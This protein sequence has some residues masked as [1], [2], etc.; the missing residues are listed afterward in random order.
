MD[1]AVSRTLTRTFFVD[2]SPVPEPFPER[3]ILVVSELGF[4]SPPWDRLAVFVDVDGARRMALNI[5]GE[6]PEGD[7]LVVCDAGGEFCNIL[8]GAFLEA[9]ARGAAV[10][11]AFD[12]R[13]VGVLSPGLYQ[14]PTVRSYATTEGWSLYV[15]VAPA[16][17]EV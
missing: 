3:R 4:S 17:G 2:A 7:D 10:E 8:A 5:L 14:S 13:Q 15:D 16:R 9:E 11:T 1:S 6:L 12:V